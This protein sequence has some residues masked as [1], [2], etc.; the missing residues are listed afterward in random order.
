MS[1]LSLWIKEANILVGKLSSAGQPGVCKFAQGDIEGCE[2]PEFD[3]S[4]WKSVMGKGAP[5]NGINV[6]SVISEKKEETLDLCDWSMTGGPAAM[7]KRIMLPQTI[8]GIDTNGSKVYITMTMLAPLE[9]YID[10][11]LSAAYKY[12]GDSRQCEI[13]ITDRYKA[14]TE[15]VAVF[16]TPQN[17]G[18]AHLGVY[19]NCEALEEKML[20]LTTAVAQLEFAE[21]LLSVE[22]EMVS[23]CLRK[24]EGL[25]DPDAISRRDWNKIET[26]LKGIDEILNN[27][28]PVAKKFRVHLI[29]HSHMDMN[30]LWN[31]EETV[32]ICV[33]DFRTIVNL[34]DENPDLKFSQSQSCVYDIVQK[35]DPATFERVLQK[36][37]EGVWEVTAATWSEH[38]LYTSGSETFANQ[39]LAAAKYARDVLKTSPSRI[40]WEPDTFGHPA[41]IPNIMTKA[42]VEYYYHFRCNPGHALKWWEGTDGSRIL[43]FCFGPYNNAL[44]PANIMPVVNEFWD[45]F[46]VKS[47]MFVFG[48]G[49]HGGGPTRRDIRVKRFLDN[50]PGLP[51]LLFSKACDFFDEALAIKKDWPVYKGEQQFIFEGCYTLKTKIKKILRDGDSRLN[52]AQ[53]ALAYRMITQKNGGQNQTE[54]NRAWEKICFNGFHDISC[55]C[56]IKDADAY[57]FRIGNEAIATAC[58][59]ADGCIETRGETGI[60]IFNT[61]GFSRTDAVCADAPKGIPE[62]GMIKSSDG[63]KTAYQVMGGKIYFI[64]KEVPALSN[65][66]YTI[67]EGHCSGKAMPCRIARGLDDGSVFGMESSRYVLEISARTGTIVTLYDKL[68]KKDVLKRLKGFAEVPGAFY[69]QKSSNLFKMVYEEP[70]IMSAWVLGNEFS[71]RYLITAPDISVEQSGSV[72]T[73]L[74]I[75]RKYNDSLFIQYITLYQ[76]LDRVDMEF[77]LDWRELGHHT[78]GVPVLKVCFSGDMEAPEYI[79]ETPF[80]SVKRQIQNAEVP[81]YRYVAL[82]E[83]DRALA[84][85]NDNKHGFYASG[86]EIA[87]TLVRGSYSPD[88]SPDLGEVTGKYAVKPYYGPISRAKIQKDAMAFNSPFVAKTGALQDSGADSCIALDSDSIVITSIK[89]SFDG[90]NVVVIMQEAEGRETEASLAFKFECKAVWEVDLK[91]DAVRYLTVADSKVTVRMRENE[92]KSIMFIM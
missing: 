62:H 92:I 46:G 35:N 88:A 22:P 89:P 6:D 67:E 66:T 36:I 20:L 15:H 90:K 79:Y 70:H 14:G 73:R 8:E 65:K 74:K 38:D 12:W 83:E 52:D 87:M 53:A 21:K 27:I 42:G 85:F 7:R 44:R 43:D 82:A 32:D 63:E 10:G 61:L 34:L 28:D 5:I 23:E 4:N 49:D 41:T 9:I 91:Q 58:E 19:I 33:R 59:I 75:E 1:N 55:G 13:M 2:S 81:S 51:T 40:C 17:D 54:L 71:H 56:N 31:Y 18:D 60:T 50:K 25:L 30:W 77:A 76:E 24:L 11:S 3:D 48:V 80:G 68:I 37:K 69:A 45:N 57:D 86:S 39:I 72:F 64:A 47:S 26:D 78:T 16:K 29:A 84:L